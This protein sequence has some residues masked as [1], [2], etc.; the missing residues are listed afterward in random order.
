MGTLATA[1]DASSNQALDVLDAPQHPTHHPNVDL[2]ASCTTGTTTEAS[3]SILE[4][5]V[6]D[7][8]MKLY[9]CVVREMCVGAI[10]VVAYL[11]PSQYGLQS[12]LQLTMC[13]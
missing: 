8:V 7:A 13:H 11:I 10:G 6:E 1:V 9:R 12:N 2:L 5:T 4:G 3:L